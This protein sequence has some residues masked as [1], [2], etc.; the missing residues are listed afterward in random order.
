MCCWGSS[1]SVV[2]EVHAAELEWR[3]HDGP[4]V[5]VPKRKGF[6]STLLE[7]VLG[8]QLQGDFR[9]EYLPEGIRERVDASLMD[10]TIRKSEPA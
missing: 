8:R 1:A 9:T 4:P 10:H 6:G 3:E 7:R 2:E 5:E